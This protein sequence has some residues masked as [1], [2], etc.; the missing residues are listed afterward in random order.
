MKNQII[1][2]IQNFVE[3]YPQKQNTSTQWGVPIIGFASA[4]D[5]LF[6]RLSSVASPTHAIPTDFLSGAKTVVAFF[7]PFQKKMTRTNIK[8]RICSEEW[9]VAYIETNEMIRQLSLFLQ[10]SFHSKGN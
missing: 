4:Q 3:H 10:E 1:K 6:D 9:G 2:E 7:L 8:N 5:P